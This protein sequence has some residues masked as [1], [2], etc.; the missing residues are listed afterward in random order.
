MSNLSTI[1]ITL[2]SEAYD[3]NSSYERCDHCS[4]DSRHSNQGTTVLLPQWGPV[5]QQRVRVIQV[6]VGCACMAGQPLRG[7]EGKGANPHR[8]VG[9]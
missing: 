5:D 4:L 9:A 3:R 7:G 6:R 2:L 1:T 8:P